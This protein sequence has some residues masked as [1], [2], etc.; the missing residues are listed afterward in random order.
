[1]LP[2]VLTGGRNAVQ[3]IQGLP[4]LWHPSGD[5][6]V[7]HTPGPWKA[8][9]TF[10]E[11]ENTFWGIYAPAV[12]PKQFNGERVGKVLNEADARLIAAAPDLLEALRELV[13]EHD[14]EP[15]GHEGP[16]YGRNDTGGI[17]LAR[18]AIRK[19]TGE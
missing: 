6:D 8:A 16:W 11:N 19:A 10:V 7:T 9:P 14:T 3:P 13:T 15:Y 5:R 18:D 17:V 1:M 4:R 2:P 12:C